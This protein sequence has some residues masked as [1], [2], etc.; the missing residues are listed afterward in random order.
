MLLSFSVENWRSF[1]E[2]TELS[3]L[4]GRERQHSERLLAIPGSK[5]KAL[6]VALMYG[7]NGSGKSNF[8]KALIF[9]KNLIVKGTAHGRPIL[10]EPF[11]L[12]P[13]TLAQPSCFSLVIQI[14]EMRYFFYLALN[15]SGVVEERLERGRK[16]K[17][18]V[19]YKRTGQKFQLGRV[20]QKNSFLKYVCQG[21]RANQLFLTNAVEQ[22]VAEL[23][24]LYGWFLHQLVLIAPETRFD[25]PQSLTQLA[26]LL[27]QINRMLPLLDTGISRIA[28]RKM[29]PGAVMVP[30]EVRLRVLDELEDNGYIRVFDAMQRQQWFF[31]QR[32]GELVAYKLV[33]YHNCDD[34][35]E[36]EFDLKDESD[37]TNRILDLLP[38]FLAM[39]KSSLQRVYFIDELDRS[40]HSQLTR[41][42]LEVYLQSIREGGAN[43]LLVVTHDT[44]LMDQN[45]FRR[46]EIWLAERKQQGETQFASLQKQESIRYDKD[47]RRSYLQ[48]SLGGVPRLLG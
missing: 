19:I 43:Q 27:E 44:L 32:Q 13:E 12:C 37:G 15:R 42:L 41:Y 46:D 47:V 20:F 36:I 35:S 40:L 25:F 14:E 16:G 22:N 28:F 48:G 8:F 7:G 2:K 26:P 17:K 24:P 31:S 23:E 30:E 4:A 1:K 33:S 9:L 39:S 3:L 34:G 38:A 21:T 18:E 45:L 6:P 5:E 11:R 10:V 29:P